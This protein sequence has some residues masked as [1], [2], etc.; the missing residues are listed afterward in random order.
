MN[1]NQLAFTI[2]IS[3]EMINIAEKLS[4]Q[5]R[6]EKKTR[7]VYLNTL[8]LLAVEFFCQCM[9]IETEFSKSYGLDSVVL[10]LMNTASIFIKDKGLLECRPVLPREEFCEIPPEILSERIGYMVVEI[11]ELDRQAK[12]VGFVESV[13]NEKLAL[14]KLGSMQDFLIYLQKLQKIENYDP[15]NPDISEI[16]R[17]Q[18]NES[19]VKLSKWFKGLLDS[20]WESEL[21]IAKDIPNVLDVPKD[22]SPVN[23]TDKEEVGGAKIIH[24]MH[25]SEPVLLILRQTRLSPDEIEIILRLYP[26]SESIF[27]LDGIKMTLL[28]EK[29][30]PIRQL[31]KQAK[32]SNWLQLRF[33][34]NIG[35]KFSLKISFR[36]DSVITKFII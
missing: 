22:I 34:G 5:Q 6:N 28:D 8:A 35:D 24:L 12:I 36:E 32:A 23:V 10:S 21:A 7:E 1:S 31:E 33:K 29:D 17:N 25:L 14:S 3:G 30:N 15:Y 26:A 13:S 9:E 27:L 4:Q 16:A 11:D 2:P 18:L 19:I 20:G